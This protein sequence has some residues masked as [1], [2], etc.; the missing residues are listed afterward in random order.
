MNMCYFMQD[1]EK[2]TVE[3]VYLILANW[4]P[5]CWNKLLFCRHKGLLYVVINNYVCNKKFTEFTKYW[6]TLVPLE[7]NIALFLLCS[8]T[9]LQNLCSFYIQ[10][11]YLFFNWWKVKHFLISEMMWHLYNT[12]NYWAFKNMTGFLSNRHNIKQEVS[13]W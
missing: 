12:N 13:K 5:F 8:I 4:L 2:S 1:W 9:L 11:K 7:H 6:Y 3:C 10:I